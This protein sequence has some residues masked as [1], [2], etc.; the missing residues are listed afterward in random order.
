MIK[1]YLKEILKHSFIYGIGEVVPSIL[2]IFLIPLYTRFLT[3][4]DYG[5]L[6]V[7]TTYVYL[8]SLVFMQGQDVTLLR[9]YYDS[10]KVGNA[11]SLIKTLA[12][13]IACV[14]IGV[15]CILLV[16]GFSYNF[17][18]FAAVPFYPYGFIAMWIAAISVFLELFMLVVRL[19]GRPLHYIF[20]TI[21]QFLLATGFIILF[22]V[23]CGM[24]ADGSLLGRLIAGGIVAFFIIRYV[25]KYM[26]GRFDARVLRSSLAFGLPSVP[27]KL[28]MRCLNIVDIFLLERLSNLS[29][30]G[31]YTLGYKYA[32]VLYIVV[33]AVR[34]VWT[35][36]FYKSESEGTGKVVFPQLI[37]YYFIVL[38][39]VA[40]VFS[41]FAREIIALFTTDQYY[42]SYKVVPYLL[43]SFVCMG[44]YQVFSQSIVV[45]NKVYLL[46]VCSW[47]ALLVGVICHVFLIPRFGMMGA[48]YSSLIAFA[49]LFILGVIFS[50][51]LYPM[52]INWQMMFYALSC[53]VICILVSGSIQGV[54]LMAA[55]MIK[56]SI[57]LFYAVFV[58]CF[59]LDALERRHGIDYIVNRFH[60][61]FERYRK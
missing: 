37:R 31:L 54:S 42:E 23:F 56:L 47:S 5:I 50:Q 52:R 19:E 7:M 18:F 30:L 10:K 4:G 14:V 26:R 17:T 28:G 15:N 45:K 32:T 3:P 49:L 20:Y 53:A 36:A 9:G 34:N 59:S 21:M 39:G 57:C 24:R 55:I 44:M 12:I 6:S 29:Q 16:A 43:I 46:P 60:V 41:V 33:Y 8:L 25:K 51:R 35:P 40:V 58:F 11:G 13:Y 38:L 48:A 22:V 2:A 61:C 27:A 1:K